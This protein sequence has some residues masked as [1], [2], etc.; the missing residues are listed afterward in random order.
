MCGNL[1]QLKNSALGA[2]D[3]A[4]CGERPFVYDRVG[5]M[6]GPTVCEKQWAEILVSFERQHEDLLASHP[7]CKEDLG[8]IQ[9]AL[10]TIGHLVHASPSNNRNGTVWKDLVIKAEVERAVLCKHLCG[11]ALF[12]GMLHM[13]ATAHNE[14]NKTLQ[15]K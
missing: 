5:E 8:L 10:I 12:T 9:A 14:M 11:K 7:D 6:V 1:T 4:P 13:Y 15:P 2:A 3:G